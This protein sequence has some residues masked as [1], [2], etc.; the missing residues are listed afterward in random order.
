MTQTIPTPAAASA[1][2]PFWSALAQLTLAESRRLTRE[3][4]FL[5][6]TVGFPV[7][8]YSLFGLPRDGMPL[9]FSRTALLNLAAFSLI[10]LSLF[11]FGVNVAD[12]RKVGWLRLLRASPMPLPTYI[13]AKVLA[14][15]LYGGAAVALLM[16]FAG[17]VGGVWLGWGASVE[18]C[19]NCCWALRRWSH[20]DWRWAFW[21]ARQRRLWWRTSPVC[22][23]CSRQVW[24]CR[25][26]CCLPS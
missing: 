14:A 2:P 9:E 24:P 11:S 8:F 1:R 10:S 18:A 7:L 22:C 5:L 20:W 19:S 26:K 12:E 15:W 6:G 23:W 3:P 16:T 4:M 21:C 13:L 25:W 17:V